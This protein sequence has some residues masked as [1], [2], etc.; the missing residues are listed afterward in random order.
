MIILPNPVINLNNKTNTILTNL[1]CYSTTADWGKKFSKLK[2]GA[3]KI[4]VFSKYYLKKATTI[5][6][7]FVTDKGEKQKLTIV[8]NEIFGQNKHLK[9]N[10]CKNE[11]EFYLDINNFIE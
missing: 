6:L 3:E 1:Y 5:T 4:V 7:E 11:K 9:V 10:I 8:D 2:P